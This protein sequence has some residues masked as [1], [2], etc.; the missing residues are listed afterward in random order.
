MRFQE[1]SSQIEAGAKEGVVI[2]LG[3]MN[4]DLTQWQNEAY[5][6]RKIAEEYQACIGKNGL[7]LLDY[8]ITWQ[9]IHKDGSIHNSAL[10]HTFTNSPLHINSYKK[11]ETGFS[12]HWAIT[13]IINIH[14]QK[15]KVQNMESRDMRKLRNNPLKF[16]EE[17]DK[18][19]W[20]VAI[21]AYILYA[22]TLSHRIVILTRILL[23]VRANHSKLC[24]L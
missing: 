10:D 16:K 19:E 13:A 6:L 24:C 23:T 14:L 21:P 11:V 3:D 8:G 1:F 20:S 22:Y 9:R 5:Y 7:E 15:A 12:D 4:I 2:G 17:L 18:I